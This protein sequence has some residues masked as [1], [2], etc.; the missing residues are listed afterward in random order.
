MDAGGKQKETGG[1]RSHRCRLL[2][3][4]PARGISI[5]TRELPPPAGLLTYASTGRSAFP[6]PFRNSGIF[7]RSSAFTV[8][9][10]CWNFTSFPNTSGN[11]TAF[12]VYTKTRNQ[13]KTGERRWARILLSVCLS[14]LIFSISAADSKPDKKKSQAAYQRGVH[15]ADAGKRD[16]AI[17]AFT[18]AID[19]D[20]TN[21]AALRARALQYLAA[22]E[23]EKC[24]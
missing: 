19:A 5:A 14:G 22:G 20:R 16:E 2:P 24:A 4:E 13:M 7:D 9:G 23:R 11:S 21:T 18:E 1:V 17:A 10:L 8:A 12:R 3:R 15:A 6:F